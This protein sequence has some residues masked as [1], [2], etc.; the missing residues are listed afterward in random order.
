MCTSLVADLK[1]G[2]GARLE[3]NYQRRGGKEIMRK[4][5]THLRMGTRA[6]RNVV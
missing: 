4:K 6:R 2:G 3:G 1:G 5:E